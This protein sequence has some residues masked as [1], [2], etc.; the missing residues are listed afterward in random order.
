MWSWAGAGV[1]LIQAAEAGPACAAG[2]LFALFF[3][4]CWANQ[5][6]NGPLKES[7]Q[8]NKL[9]YVHDNI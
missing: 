2:V 8:V 9:V 3:F 7:P 5:N 1:S 4:P 6:C